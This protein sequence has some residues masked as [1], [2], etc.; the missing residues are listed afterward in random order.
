MGWLFR[1]STPE[2]RPILESRLPGD[3]DRGGPAP[4]PPPSATPPGVKIRPS[5]APSEATA[6]LSTGAAFR[7][8]LQMG[9]R[10]LSLPEEGGAVLV[11]S[12]ETPVAPVIGDVLVGSAAEL[13]RALADGGLRCLLVH[14][15]PGA[16]PG[17]RRI[18]RDDLTGE[19]FPGI[20]GLRCLFRHERVAILRLGPPPGARWVFVGLRALAVFTG[21]FTVID[22]DQTRVVAAGEL[23]VVSDPSATLYLQA[24]NDAAVGIG[25]A[26][27]GVIA[28]LG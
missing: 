27:P 19:P 1:K 24:G 12:G 26:S 5:A 3:D 13:T 28:A 22:G 11:L 16:P 10:D 25:F 15:S 9:A 17:F 21:R 7:I 18:G 6:E 20:T 14:A 23:A 4:P 8:F 2:A